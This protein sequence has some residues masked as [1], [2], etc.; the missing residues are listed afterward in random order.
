MNENEKE[1]FSELENKLMLCLGLCARAGKI[2]FGVP[3]ICDAMR[4]K[5]ESKVPVIVF[6]SS[7]TSENTHKKITDKCGYYK[8]KVVRL[9]KNGIELA[10]ALGKT[11]SLAA[12]A[13][14]DVQM[15]KM[16]E[17]YI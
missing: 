12:I 7:D 4:R 17:K 13:V 1:E 11:G 9:K 16:I 8:I 5:G 10:Q 15:S 6:E 14:T 2:I 3:M